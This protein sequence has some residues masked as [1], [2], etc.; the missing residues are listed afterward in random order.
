MDT[1]PD[2]SHGRSFPLVQQRIS[3]W[4]GAGA[5]SCLTWGDVPQG[6]A[7]AELEDLV[8]LGSV[9]LEAGE[10]GES[11]CWKGAGIRL[12]PSLLR[13]SSVIPPLWGALSP[14]SRS[15]GS[16]GVR[17]APEPQCNASCWSVVAAP[18][19]FWR[20]LRGVT[21]SFGDRP[22]A[23]PAPRTSGRTPR[24]LGCPSPATRP[25]ST[26]SSR[27]GSRTPPCPWPPRP[28]P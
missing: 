27:S 14:A 9:S 7:S 8:F 10:I 2:S 5:P 15:S 17:V 18:A 28:R 13:A 26:R 24:S 11:V 21:A 19:W 23:C 22:Q 12:T 6:L 1:K 16:L 25:G 20:A 4:G 3:K